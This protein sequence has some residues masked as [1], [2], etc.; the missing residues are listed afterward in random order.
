VLLLCASCD[1]H[2]LPEW[3]RLC[4]RCGFDFGDGVE[5]GRTNALPLMTARAWIVL[6]WMIAGAAVFLAYFVWLFWK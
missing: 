4:P 2:F 5:I 1:D 6:G 3:Y